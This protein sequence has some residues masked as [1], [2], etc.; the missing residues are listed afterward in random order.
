MRISDWSSDVCSSD[1]VLRRVHRDE[2]RHRD[3]ALLQ[4]FDAVAGDGDTAIFPTRR[5][6][7]RQRLDMLDRLVG[8]H[9]PIGAE[10][11]GRKGVVSGKRGYVRE[12]LGGRRS[13]KKK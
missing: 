5:K 10:F 9:R 2:H 6:Q 8:R 7:L 4:M 11:R 1:L 13:I 12:E 3:L